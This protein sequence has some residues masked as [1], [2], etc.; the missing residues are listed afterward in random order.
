MEAHDGIN[1]MLL[2]QFRCKQLGIQAH[3]NVCQGHGDIATAEQREIADKWESQPPPTGD[4]YQMWE[5]VS[6]GSPQTPVFTTLDGLVDWL[7]ENHE[8][9]AGTF[10]SR[11]EWSTLLSGQAYGI[12]VETGSVV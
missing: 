7:V 12:D 4:G 10:P 3:C 6:E 9:V 5:T 1:R 11:D 8:N 2:I